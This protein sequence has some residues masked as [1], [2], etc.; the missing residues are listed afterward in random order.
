MQATCFGSLEPS[1]GLYLYLNTDPN[2]FFYNWDPKSNS[3]KKSHHL[4]NYTNTTMNSRGQSP[5]VHKNQSTP[6]SQVH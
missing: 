2:F 5:I 3:T 1:S 4:L 6:L